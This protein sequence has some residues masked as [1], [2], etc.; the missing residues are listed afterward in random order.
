MRLGAQMSTAGGLHTAFQRGQDAACDSM[1]IFTKSNR[2]WKAK[3]LTEE[4]I[5]AYK[6]AVEEFRH[7]LPIAV[8]ASYLINIA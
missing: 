4:D 5:A 6:T 8:H 1:L 3:T 7:I 2:Q